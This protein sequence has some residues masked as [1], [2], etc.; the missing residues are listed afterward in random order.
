METRNSQEP[1][2]IRCYLGSPSKSVWAHPHLMASLDQ[3]F[4]IKLK[5]HFCSGPTRGGAADAPLRGPQES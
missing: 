5:L 4:V 2:S 3:P 1:R